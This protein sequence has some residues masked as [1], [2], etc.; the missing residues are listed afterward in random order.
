MALSVTDNGSGM[1]R[2]VLV[3]AFEPF[4]T[5]KPL[6]Q[7]TGLGLPM[8]YGFATQ[9]NGYA[10]IYSEPGQGTTMRLYLPRHL[11]SDELA[12]TLPAAAAGLPATS[13]VV[14]VVDD[15][16]VVR[17]VL[18]D[19]L[20]DLGYQ[21]VE[22]ADGAEALEVLETGRV[23]DLLI[24]DIGLPGGMNGRQLAEA[25]RLTRLGL[26]VLFI[27]GFAEYAVLGN[28]VLAPGMQV[29]TKPFTMDSLVAK[30]RLMIQT[31]S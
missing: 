24:T 13:G 2:D 3:R 25:A 14:L 12:A 18:C 20:R 10:S 8:V 11:G 4:F 29:I 7:G 9:S 28:G 30:V 19:V 23:V 17:M 16:P 22:A 31:V 6:G 21:V 15:E 1:T 26:Q 5:T 27:T